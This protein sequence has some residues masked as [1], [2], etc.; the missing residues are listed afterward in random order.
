MK[1]GAS[2]TL[3]LLAVIG[4]SAVH[5]AAQKVRTGFLNRALVLDGEEYRYQLYVPREFQRSVKWPV[6]LAL[7]GGGDYGND[8][9]RQT[10]GALAG[11]I[12]RFPERVPAIVVFPQAHADGKPGWHSAGGRAALAAVDK[13]I[14]EFLR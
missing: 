11:V 7:H 9:I 2:Q 12:R 6:I 1:K 8:G 3:V 5:A 13:A 10:A 14:S 4:M